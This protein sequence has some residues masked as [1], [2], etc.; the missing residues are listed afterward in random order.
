MK[1]FESKF[2]AYVMALLLFVSPL[3]GVATVAQAQTP[4]AAR[5]YTMIDLT[6]AGSTTSSA[7]GIFGAQQVG[8]AAFGATTSVNHAVLWNGSASSVVDLG[9]G[10]ASAI[11]DGQQV[12]SANNH[13]ALW[14]G[15][16]DSRVDLNPANWGQSIAVGTRGGQ[17]VG[18]AT[19]QVQC[20]VGKQCG[21][22]RT[23][24]E[25]HPFL[26]YGSA[27]SAVDLTPLVLGFGAGRALGTDGTQQVGTGYTVIGINAW[28][29][30][31]AVLWS[32]TAASAVNLNPQ[33]SIASQA[34]AVSGGQ[35]VG[36]DFYPRH[37]LLWNGSAESAVDLHPAGNY[38]TSEANATNG[39]QQA[40]FGFVG[41]E[42]TQIGHSHAL[43]W[44][45]TPSSA[46]DLNQFMP[47]GFT[48]A[49][50]T[51]INANGNIVGWASTGTPANPANVH[52]VMWVPSRRAATF[53]QSVTV[54]Q[55]SIVAGE[56]AQATVTL[57][58]PAP[59]GGAVVELASVVTPPPGVTTTTPLAVTMPSSV[60][61]AAG[62][63]SASF[64]V[65]T[66]AQTLTG[67]TRA[68][69]VD[70]QAA[71]GDTT[72]TGVMEVSPPLSLL[73]FS[74]A[75]GTVVGGNTAVGT[76]TLS[77]A[78]PSGGAL[79]TLTSNNAAALIP[80]SVLIPAGQT[81]ATFTAQTS[82][83]A[84]LTTATLRATYGS[85]TTL[86]KTATLLI[87]PSNAQGDTVAIQKADY[88]SS[89]R[90]L[91]VQATS[92]S[93]TATLTVTVTSTRQVIGILTNKG[94]GKYAGTFSLA[95][96]PQNITVTS[97][98]TGKASRAVSLK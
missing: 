53:A 8:T 35:Q 58:R 52:A 74:V 3:S 92:T 33:G 30:P 79:V 55:T 40:G 69:L 29:G 50:A 98:L 73:S 82:T 54:D 45:G 49:A 25:F 42:A 21:G 72:Q 57:N 12:G 61:V 1:D 71:Y 38:A 75:P 10:T 14:S 90:E 96:N 2:I 94:A 6:P 34:N 67:F 20:N 77:G 24:T 59:A 93:P 23:K 18:S 88:V 22:S 31:Y 76:V 64:T 28:S 9:V 97:N 56:T 11:R 81:S 83:V 15:T 47:L 26:W 89:K 84:A 46:I 86:T 78:A 4:S 51:G 62:Q 60:T 68:Y 87:A 32:G 5:H 19:R 37:A 43:V 48:D 36:F 13:A 44:S 39:T 65:A 41:D 91:T 95:T 17:Q 27:A 16:A 7:A 85:S 66:S 63:T 80:P 70:I